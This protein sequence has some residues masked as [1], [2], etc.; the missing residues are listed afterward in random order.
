MSSLRIYRHVMIALLLSVVLGGYLLENLGVAYVSEGGSPIQKIHL[1]SYIILLSV[2]LLF[3][4]Q[5][6]KYTLLTLGRFSNIWLLSIL[7]LAFVILYGLAKYGTSGMAYLINTFLSPLL[8]FPL[9]ARLDRKQ[10]NNILKLI[11]Y[12][13]LINSLIALVEYALQNRF[14]DVEIGSF[15]H[16]R[17]TALMTHPLNNALITVS[18]A[19]LLCSQTRLPNFVYFGVTVLAL[20]SFG[21]RAALAVFCLGAMA[22]GLPGVWRF[23]VQGIQVNKVKFALLVLFGYLSC[24]V[25]VG[26]LLGTGIT[27]RIASKMYVDNSAMA[28][29]DVFYLLEQLQPNEWLFGASENLLLNIESYIGISVIENYIIGW[30]LTF[31]LIGTLPLMLCLLSPL[32][33][34]YFNG[35][36]S[37]KISIL[38]FLIAGISNNSL[39]TKTPVLLIIFT[40]VF[41]VYKINRISNSTKAINGENSYSSSSAYSYL[42]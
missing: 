36:F 28:R 37:T 42:K 19:I 10:L 38:V 33:Y 40:V 41:C 3:L 8:I 23:F 20:F 22:V 24:V 21:G 9:L 34:F 1:Y 32:S 17:S 2:G 27:E 6:L 31:G 35:N 26:A 18:V 5:G 12:L 25:F 15:S 16:F 4:S 11:A 39:T 14:V 30:I 7:C 29:F 13:I